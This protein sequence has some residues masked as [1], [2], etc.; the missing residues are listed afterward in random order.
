[1]TPLTGVVAYFLVPYLRG[2]VPNLGEALASGA[3]EFFAFSPV[4]HV[5]VP[6]V[7]PFVCTVVGVLVGRRRGLAGQATDAKIVGGI[8][9]L[10]FVTALAL[11]I[12]TAVGIAFLGLAIGG[13]FGLF[14]ATI[15]LLGESAGAGYLLAR[16]ARRAG[17]AGA[18][19]FS[20]AT[21]TLG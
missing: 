2:N 14:I 13:I 5:F 1:M 3:M 11:F 18:V 19:A 15:V 4:Y 20:P 6:V 16:R 21:V 17:R 9:L 10:P 12:L 7:A 8:V